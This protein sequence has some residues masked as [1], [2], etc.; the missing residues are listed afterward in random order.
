MKAKRTNKRLGGFRY[1]RTKAQILDYMKVPAKRKLQWIEEMYQFNRRVAR[2]NPT[3][4][5]IQEKF[6]RGEI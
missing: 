4:A 1:F 5:K 2:G 6:R 3:I